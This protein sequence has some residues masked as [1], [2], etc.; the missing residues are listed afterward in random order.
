M[1]RHRKG[2][3]LGPIG[4]KYLYVGG[5]FDR[6]VKDGKLVKDRWSEQPCFGFK[7]VHHIA[8]CWLEAALNQECSSWDHLWIKLAAII[9]QDTCAARAGDVLLMR[10]YTEW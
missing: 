10:G 6:L 3:C 7:T 2:Q 9:L 8:H 4:R 5:H 1:R